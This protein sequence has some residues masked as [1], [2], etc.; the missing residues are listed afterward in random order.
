MKLVDFFA[1]HQKVALA[2][3]GGV[4]SS[5]LLYAAKKA[6]ADVKAYYAKSDFQPEFEFKDAKLLAAEL[7]ADMEMIYLDILADPVIV[8]NPADR[9]YTCKKYIMAKPQRKKH[10]EGVK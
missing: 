8:S 1:E 3:S 6:G 5:Y 7:G 9:C 10:K 4:D 2:F